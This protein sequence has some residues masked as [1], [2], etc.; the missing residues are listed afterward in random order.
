MSEDRDGWSTALRIVSGLLLALALLTGVVVVA[1]RSGARITGVVT[2]NGRPVP[3]ARVVRTLSFSNEGQVVSI[4]FIRPR[5]QMVVAD[6]E[7]RYAFENV[8]TDV[9]SALYALPAVGNGGVAHVDVRPVD[10]EEIRMDLSVP[11]RGSPTR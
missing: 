7:G 8:R 9:I 2:Q 5:E 10:G 1:N 3:G 11:V 4:P 6:D